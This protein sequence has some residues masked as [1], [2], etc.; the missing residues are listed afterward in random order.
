MK[1]KRPRKEATPEQKAAAAERRE[2]I[3]GLMAKVRAIAPEQRVLLAATYGIRNA[4]GRELSPYNQNLLHFQMPTVSVVGG[5]SQW[6]KLDRHVLK[7]SR[8]LSIWVPIRGKSPEA[9]TPESTS[10][11]P[12]GTEPTDAET[13]SGAFTLGSVFDITQTE[14][15]A[16]RDHRRSLEGLQIL[17]E[18]L[19]LTGPTAQLALSLI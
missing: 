14:T 15:S 4:E 13:R 9:N 7:G 11:V 3:K 10:L 1:T 17:P 5:F 12:H 19:A 8:A 16:E 6:A 18:R 2:Q